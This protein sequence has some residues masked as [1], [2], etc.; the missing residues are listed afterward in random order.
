MDKEGEVEG[1]TAGCREE[2]T[3]CTVLPM[4]GLTSVLLVCMD[5]VR[6]HAHHQIP[7]IVL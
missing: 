6:T 5:T 3:C 4:A 2:A 1:V 7:S